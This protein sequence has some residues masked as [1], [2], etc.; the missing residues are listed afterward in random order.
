VNRPP[1]VYEHDDWF[2]IDE[3]ADRFRPL[4]NDEYGNQILGALFVPLSLN[5]HQWNEYQMMRHSGLPKRTYSPL[6]Y[7]L[8]QAEDDYV[9][10]VGNELSPGVTYLPKKVDRYWTTQGTM[11]AAELNEAT[12][13][14]T[15]K[16]A[17]EQLRYLDDAWVKYNYDSALADELY[18]VD[19]ARSRVLNGKGANLRRSD[20]KKLRADTV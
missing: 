20:V 16:L 3:R 9:G 1:G 15:P 2:T 14:F 13:N 7:T 11:T 10:T 8:L 12:R 5:S 18:G 19:Q 17:S 6:P 4:L